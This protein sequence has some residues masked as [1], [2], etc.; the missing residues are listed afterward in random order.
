M[1]KERALRCSNPIPSSQAAINRMKAVRSKNT[2]PEKALQTAL[3]SKGLNFQIN[4]K[5][6]KYLNRKADIVINAAKVAIFVDGCF[7]HGCPIHGTH[8]KANPEFW[9]NKIA[10]NKSRD[11]DTNYELK[12]YGWKVIRIWEHEDPELVSKMIFGIIKRRLHKFGNDGSET[13]ST[14]TK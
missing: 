9:E 4:V 6:I 14:S 12:K 10:Q 3:R 11:L 2:A 8:S 5:P 13:I 1:K 7:W